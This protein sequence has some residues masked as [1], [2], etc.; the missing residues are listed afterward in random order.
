MNRRRAPRRSSTTQSE[1]RI[2]LSPSQRAEYMRHGRC[3][4]SRPLSNNPTN[5]P[6]ARRFLPRNDLPSNREDLFE[7]VVQTTTSALTQNRRIEELVPILR[8]FHHCR[9]ED[10][11]TVLADVTQL[12]ET[13]LLALVGLS[14][15]ITRIPTTL[16]AAPPAPP[17]TSSRR[18]T[19]HS[20]ILEDTNDKRT[21]RPRPARATLLRTGSCFECFSPGHVRIN[22]RWYQCPMCHSA[23]PG[24]L[25]RLCPLR[26]TEDPPVAAT[27]T[28]DDSFIGNS[29][30]TDVAPG[31]H[32]LIESD[33]RPSPQIPE[34]NPDPDILIDSRLLTSPV[35]NS[36]VEEF[37]PDLIVT[38]SDEPLTSSSLAVEEVTHEE[39]LLQEW[40]DVYP[41]EILS[42]TPT[43]FVPVTPSPLR[44][45]FV[46][47]SITPAPQS[48]ARFFPELESPTSTSLHSRSS[49]YSDVNSRS[50]SPVNDDTEDSA[51]S[52]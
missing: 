20:V 13:D 38:S 28:N 37:R 25:P 17:V 51:W 2:T 46:E 31:E 36:T 12:L 6:R 30:A 42:P 47:D 24:H 4:N 19:H 11:S 29:P 41:I 3:F 43:R 16:P 49:D 8:Q 18:R 21:P 10:I 34:E 39:R 1:E 50:S 27:A 32:L 26:V 5:L 22:C 40:S 14:E 48:P 35:L 44:E 7:L 23:R 9:A 45:Y 33:P 15:A 52:F